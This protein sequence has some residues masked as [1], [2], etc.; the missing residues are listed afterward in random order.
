MSFKDM[1]CVSESSD[2]NKKYVLFA[3]SKHTTYKIVFCW[4]F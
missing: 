2:D 3:T 1:M 4:H